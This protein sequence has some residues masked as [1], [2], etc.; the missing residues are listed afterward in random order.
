MEGLIIIIRPLYR[1]LWYFLIIWLVIHQY[2]C[3]QVS[4]TAWGHW[5]PE[6]W[7]NCVYGCHRWGCWS[8]ALHCRHHHHHH[9][10]YCHHYYSHCHHQHNIT[11]NLQIPYDKVSTNTASSIPKTSEFHRV[12]KMVLNINIM[13]IEQKR[14]KVTPPILVRSLWNE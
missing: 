11:D 8:V 14:F 2:D 3:H 7:E 6:D 13:F 1:H 5:H 12:V 10:D 9:Q 4:T